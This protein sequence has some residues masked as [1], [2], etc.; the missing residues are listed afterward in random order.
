MMEFLAMDG[1]AV[2]VWPSFGIT[3][4]VLVWGVVA[5]WRRHRRLRRDLRR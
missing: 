3:A 5:P 1:F 4:V 2:Y